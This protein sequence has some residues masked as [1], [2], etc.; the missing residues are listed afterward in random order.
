[1]SARRKPTPEIWRWEEDAGCLTLDAQHLAYRVR[2]WPNPQV[3]QRSRPSQRWQAIAPQRRM[4][5]EWLDR[6]LRC[7]P[8]DGGTGDIVPPRRD[9]VREAHMTHAD[10]RWL[11]QFPPEEEEAERREQ[12]WY[13]WTTPRPDREALARAFATIPFAHRDRVARVAPQQSAW[14]TH[15]TLARIPEIGALADEVPLLAAYLGTW[16]TFHHLRPWKALRA[17]VHG[18]EGMKR[19]RALAGWLRLDD[20]AS[21]VNF[22]RRLPPPT[23]WKTDDLIMVRNLW[24]DTAARKRLRHG[25]RFHLHTLHVLQNARCDGVVDRITDGFLASLPEGDGEVMVPE[26]L[27][28][29]AQTWA[30][31]YPR[32]PFPKLT[33]VDALYAL[34]ET[35]REEIVARVAAAAPQ[36]EPAEPEA[37]P[38][39]PPP[40]FA[41]TDLIAPLT[42]A[43]ALH[44]EGAEMGHCLGNGSWAAMAQHGEGYGW[45]LRRGEARASLWTQQ[46][47]ADPKVWRIGE[48]R[49]PGN[50][51]VPH[52]LAQEARTWLEEACAALREDRIALSAP[53]N[54]KRTPPASSGIP[55]A[56]WWALPPETYFGDF[57]F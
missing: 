48:F 39:F 35:L 36:S 10:R 32:R 33:D 52:A 41:G 44:A 18:A 20:S 6:V 29:A 15:V 12:S 23:G 2:L 42:S 8:D 9:P 38:T 55:T 54:E 25:A 19:W 21:F 16:D 28:R 53:W 7:P 45:A 22:L 34:L 57:P 26:N 5:L 56:W 46:D 50:V 24:A 49:G 27:S 37:A 47:L 51:A 43:D 14:L 30:S 13:R 3:W 17:I 31:L 40:P 11:A 4:H 1:M